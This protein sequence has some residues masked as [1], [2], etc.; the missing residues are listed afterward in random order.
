MHCMCWFK[1]Y[2][3]KY[4]HHTLTPLVPELFVVVLAVARRELGSLLTR[5]QDFRKNHATQL[6]LEQITKAATF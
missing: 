4:G 3:G 6:V 5:G 1:M 2:F